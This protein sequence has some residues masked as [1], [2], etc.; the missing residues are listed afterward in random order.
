M[1]WL[2]RIFLII[3]F[4]PQALALELP[5]QIINTNGAKVLLLLDDSYSMN[6][7]F[8][9]PDYLR[10]RLLPNGDERWPIS[11]ERMPHLMFRIESGQSSPSITSPAK[12]A[13]MSDDWRNSWGKYYFYGQVP[14]FDAVTGKNTNLAIDNNDVGNPTVRFTFNQISEQQF[15]QKLTCSDQYCR[16]SPVEFDS[17][18]W[19]EPTLYHPP[20]PMEGVSV[21]QSFRDANFIGENVVNTDLLERKGN[22]PDGAH[23]TDINGDEYLALNIRQQQSDRKR[24]NGIW[25]STGGCDGDN[26]LGDAGYE[27][28]PIAYDPNQHVYQALALEEKGTQPTSSPTPTPTPTPT[29]LVPFCWVGKHNHQPPAMIRGFG[30]RVRFEGR[31]FELAQGIYQKHYFQWILYH[32]T[33]EQL[34]TLPT[35]TRLQVAKEAIKRL[36]TEKSS[37]I[38]FA[39]DTM[40]HWNFTTARTGAIWEYLHQ[41]GPAEYVKVPGVRIPFGATKESILMEIDKVVAAKDNRTPITNAYIRAANYF[42]N[43]TSGNGSDSPIDGAC[44]AYNVFIVSDGVPTS[45]TPRQLFGEWVRDYDGDK[46][47]PTVTNELCNEWTCELFA[48]DVAFYLHNQVDLSESLPGRQYIK[49]ATIAMEQPLPYLDKIAFNGGFDHSETAENPDNLYEILSSYANSLVVSSVSGGG[50]FSVREYVGRS[51][52][53]FR[54]SFKADWWTGDIDVFESDPQS[55]TLKYSYAV[56]EDRETRTRDLT[57]F[58]GMDQDGDEMAETLIEFS[59]DNVE[60]LSPK[61]FESFTDDQDP[62]LLTLLRGFNSSVQPANNLINYVRGNQIPNMRM[63]DRDRNGGYADYGDIVNSPVV[64]INSSSLNQKN[65]FADY[66]RF[67]GQKREDVI[68]FGSNDGIFNA[69]DSNSGKHLWGYIPSELIPD[70]HLL[71]RLDYG[72]LHRRSYVDG[73]IGISDVFVGGQWRTYVA[74]GLR[75][76]GYSFIVLDVTNHEMPRLVKEF[77]VPTLGKSWAEPEFIQVKRSSEG[78]SNSQYL[79]AADPGQYDWYLVL[80][81]GE[82][83]EATSTSLLFMNLETLNLSSKIIETGVPQGTRLG[84]IVSAQVDRDLSIDRLYFGS[85]SGNLYRL[86]LEEGV[87]PENWP[88]AKVYGGD[89]MHPIVT[90]PRVILVDNLRLE[91]IPTSDRGQYTNAVGV[92]FGTGRYDSYLDNE[93]TSGSVTQGIIGINDPVNVYGDDLKYSVTGLTKSD[94]TVQDLGLNTISYEVKDGIFSLPEG[95][96]GFH[97]KL[98]NRLNESGG[99]L[100]PAGMITSAPTIYK[101]ILLFSSFLPKPQGEKVRHRTKSYQF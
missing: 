49:T 69:V 52:Q 95:A 56:S 64:E 100:D 36:V 72:T 2:I 17:N 3:A 11:W 30:G 75:N 96:H 39:F 99:F 50:S 90:K 85:E 51:T 32:A 92:Y 82:G 14:K 35:K 5:P 55:K 61:L 18:Y 12:L 66:Q 67:V 60:A 58:T 62:T 86:G 48:D 91:Q 94:L 9:H 42:K 27:R 81:S 43:G 57:L 46:A 21:L 70:L 98:E 77:K 33:D 6:E 34:R 13:W 37:E 65:R 73:S 1:I 59:V 54:P 29:S 93:L 53:I 74:F 80:G 84:A 47:E 97:L 44:Y 8:N 23:D 25:Y 7:V 10:D 40:Y 16:S 38:D 22:D 78:N 88:L 83:S 87:S 101:G 28:E 26:A 45:E 89:L 15:I 79:G 76:G 20:L 41:G 68:F 24:I 31:E 4:I 19:I 71:S 63:R